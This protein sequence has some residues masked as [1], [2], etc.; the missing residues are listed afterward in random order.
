MLK[1]IGIPNIRRLTLFCHPTKA[2]DPIKTITMISFFIFSYIYCST[3]DEW[4]YMQEV[5]AGERAKMLWYDCKTRKNAVNKS[6]AGALAKAFK[7]FG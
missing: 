4:K 7:Q 3:L 5:V 2:R 6:K 1:S